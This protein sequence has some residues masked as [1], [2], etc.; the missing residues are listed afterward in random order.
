MTSNLAPLVF[1]AVGDEFMA[2]PYPFYAR[3]RAE[4]APLVRLDATQWIA[5]RYSPVAALLRDPR[6]RNDFPEAVQ[7]M[8]LGD[9]ASCQFVVRSALHQEQAP[10]AMLRRFLGRVVH[11]MPVEV[12]RARIGELVDD[13]VAPALE[14]GHIEIM[15]DLA[16]PL[17]LAVACELVGLPAE[18][19]PLV[20]QWGLDAVKAFTVVLPPEQRPTVDDAIVQLRAYFA[21][22][23]RAGVLA[24]QLS[25]ALADIE[26]G[27]RIDPDVLV[28]N[29]VFLFVSGFTTTVHLIAGGWAALLSHP[30]Q[31]ARLRADRSL[32]P[33]AVEEMLRYDAPIQHV[34][35]IVGERLEIDGVTLRPGRLVH[36]M[37][38]GANHDPAQ[39][40]EPATFDVGR[41]PN[42]HLSFS[43]GPHTCLGGSLGRL[44]AI[45][46]IERMLERCG[47]IEAQPP[48]R[49]PMQVF[50]SFDRVP[51][52]I[53]PA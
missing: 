1:D 45:V 46:A 19:R 24:P 36:L 11:A 44:E 34:S 21:D 30:D 7:Q 32:V 4:P 42:P 28:D 53:G 48:R 5:A 16:L 10:H 35:R 20:R 15:N 22:R 33:A 2:D 25:A 12:L 47:T 43:A 38:G 13:M 14:R 26:Q 41:S 50:R 40:P 8:K 18:D 17:P 3:V 39:F 52:V 49:R 23:L 6:L 31:L 51:A 29:V 37:L 27:E 9:G